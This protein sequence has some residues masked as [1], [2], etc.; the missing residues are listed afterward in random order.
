MVR[1]V[2]NCLFFSISLVEML[3]G[4][5]VVLVFFLVFTLSWMFLHGVCSC[6]KYFIKKKKRAKEEIRI[7]RPELDFEQNTR[8]SSANAQ[9]NTRSHQSRSV[10]LSVPR[11]T[12]SANAQENTRSHQSVILS[13]PRV[14]LERPKELR[15][16][17]DTVKNDDGLPSYQEAISTSNQRSLNSPYVYTI[18]MGDSARVDNNLPTYDAPV[19]LLLLKQHFLE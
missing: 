4:G 15:P 9:E 17:A 5:N 11:V 16:K 14:R 18:D 10:T 12:S 2:K 3:P 6:L 8:T 1:L 7:F 13:V 19:R